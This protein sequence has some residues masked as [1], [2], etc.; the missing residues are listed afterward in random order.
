MWDNT[1][2]Y[3]T[4]LGGFTTLDLTVGWTP[5]ASLKLDAGFNNLLDR[6]Y[7]YATGYPMAGR[8]GFVNAK[9]SF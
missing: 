7:A 6:N 1:S 8:T 2:S 4:R 5:V 3:T 9:Y